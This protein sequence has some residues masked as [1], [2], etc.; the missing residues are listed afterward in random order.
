MDG[1]C[2]DSCYSTCNC[3]AMRFPFIE[4]L[5]ASVTYPVRSQCCVTSIGVF[6]R[7]SSRRSTP[8]VNEMYQIAVKLVWDADGKHCCWTSV[9]RHLD[10]RRWDLFEIYNEH[11]LAL[12]DIFADACALSKVGCSSIVY[13][14]AV[15]NLKETC[16]CRVLVIPGRVA[17]KLRAGK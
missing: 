9:V 11:C 1:S 13:I 12:F 17:Y 15:T 3:N 8:S 6:S 10:R 2:C 16:H 5:A 4:G 7:S 14:H